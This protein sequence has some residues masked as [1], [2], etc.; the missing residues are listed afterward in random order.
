MDAM[1]G[2]AGIEDMDVGPKAGIR[3]VIPRAS[4]V[5]WGA[6]LSTTGL[7]LD[8]D[9]A[10]GR[11]VVGACLGAPVPRLWYDAPGAE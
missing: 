7:A 5:A 2:R 10:E 11:C 4:T 1:F 9:L 8:I 3:A 6:E